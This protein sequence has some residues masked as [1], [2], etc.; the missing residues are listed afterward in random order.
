MTLLPNIESQHCDRWL[1]RVTGCR[2]SAYLA[3]LMLFALCCLIPVNV[4]AE[5]EL[6]QRAGDVNSLI[7]G[8]KENNHGTDVFHSLGTPE[9]PGVDFGNDI[10]PLLSRYGCNSGGC[11][12]KA[13]GQN[14]F[15][16]SLFGFDQTFDYE[17][18]VL[19][20]RGR[21]LF[22]AVPDESLVLKK[23]INAVPHGG[24]ARFRADSDA[25]RMIR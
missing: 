23:A 14:G 15:K 22:P 10:V 3:Q 24:G 19:E 13:G 18:I 7:D 12:G 5:E 1:H 8:D 2:K 20:D 21:R 9:T 11:H 6:S 25:Y 17:A 4:N 16:L